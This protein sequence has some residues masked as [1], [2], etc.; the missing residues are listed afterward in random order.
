MSVEIVDVKSVN[1]MLYGGR[2]CLGV[3]AQIP[4]KQLDVKVNL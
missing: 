1:R 4:K 2:A 3:C